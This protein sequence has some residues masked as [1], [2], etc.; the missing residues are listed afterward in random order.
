[1]NTNPI[2]Y[3][4]IDHEALK[5]LRRILDEGSLLTAADDLDAYAHDEVA[6]LWHQPE[7]VARVSSTEQVSEIVDEPNYKAALEAIENA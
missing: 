6:E 7:A 1:Y 2:M 4:K 5:E 3:K